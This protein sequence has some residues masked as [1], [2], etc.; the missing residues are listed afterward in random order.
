M[1]GN[2]GAMTGA[3]DPRDPHLQEKITFQPQL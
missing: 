1:G 3:C 2:F